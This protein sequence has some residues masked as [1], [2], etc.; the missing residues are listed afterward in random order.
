MIFVTFLYSFSLDEAQLNL[1]GPTDEAFTEAEDAGI[2]PDSLEG[3]IV[4]LSQT[5]VR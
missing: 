3:N 5:G 2:I 4:Y 1:F